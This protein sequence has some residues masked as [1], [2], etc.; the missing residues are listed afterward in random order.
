MGHKK[1][2]DRKQQSLLP[3]CLDDYIPEAHICRV[4]NA[5]VEELDMETL[6]FK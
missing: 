3:I 6:G 2:I 4:I 5:F 1:G